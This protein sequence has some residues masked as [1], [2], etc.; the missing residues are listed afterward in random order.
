[1]NRVNLLLAIWAVAAAS[2]ASAKTDMR[3][4]PTVPEARIP[5]GLMERLLPRCFRS[6]PTR[7][8]RVAA[9]PAA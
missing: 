3:F 5:T 8:T 7:I 6:V 2:Q 4:K 9:S 1:M